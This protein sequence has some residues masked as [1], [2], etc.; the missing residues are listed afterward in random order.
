MQNYNLNEIN[1]IPNNTSGVYAIINMLNNHK[2]V[3]SSKD[4]RKRLYQHRCKLNNNTHHSVHLQRAFN[5]YGSDKFYVCILEVC[6]PVRD[7]LIFLEQKYLDLNPEYNI[8]KIAYSPAQSTQSDSARKKRSVKLKGRKRSKEFCE[9]LSKARMNKFGKA[10]DQFDLEGNFIR[11][12]VNTA[13]AS[14]FCG[15]YTT[16]GVAIQDCCKGK[17]KQAHGFQWRWHSSNPVNIGEYISHSMDVINNSKR[18]ICKYTMNGELIKEYESISDAAR[19][20]NRNNITSVCSNI[21]QCAKGNKKQ[22]F[23]FKW[24]YS[25]DK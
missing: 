11:T 18:R 6:Q 4:I 20:M 8:A 24:K 25:Y 10:V 22:A 19:D 14:R 23:G 1:N 2:Y 17:G 15:D 21:V 5:K 12:F 9:N 3:G 7:T 13:Q 16:R